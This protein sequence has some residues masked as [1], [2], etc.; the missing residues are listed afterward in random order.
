MPFAKG[1]RWRWKPGQS[2]NA[3]G[4]PASPKGALA[5]VG[6]AAKRGDV[7]DD[8]RI[9]TALDGLAARDPKAYLKL[10]DRVASG[11]TNRPDAQQKPIKRDGDNVT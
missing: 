11:V 4:R 5:A 9:R 10:A 3:A 1:H 6:R 2:G 8:R 7:L